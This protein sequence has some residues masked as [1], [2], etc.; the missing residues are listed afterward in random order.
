MTSIAADEFD[1]L[2]EQGAE[3]DDYFIESTPIWCGNGMSTFK[4]TVSNEL[5]QSL[6]DRAFRKGLSLEKTVIDILADS[7]AKQSHG[8]TGDGPAAA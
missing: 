7:V 1:R 6:N 5:M 2:A 3:L 4:V 8:K